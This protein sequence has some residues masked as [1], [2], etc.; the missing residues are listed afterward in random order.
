MQDDSQKKPI[1][2]EEQ[3]VLHLKDKGVTF[4]LYS[5]ND[6][7]KYL[8]NNNYYF[9]LA[10]YRKNFEQYQGGEKDGKYVNLDFGYLR[11]LAIIDM[12]LRYILLQMALDIEHYAKMDILRE[13]EKH[14]EDGYEICDDFIDSLDVKQK[15]RLSDEIERNKNTI[16]C[17][18]M[19][20]KYPEHFPVWVFLELIPF[21]RMLSFYGFCAKR[22]AEEKMKDQ[23]YMLLS[24][25][26]VRNAAAHSSCI[27]NDLH[28]KT[29]KH[30]T[31]YAV[32]NELSKIEEISD[33]MRQKR[34]SNAR[35]QE[36]VTLL[37]VHNKIVTSEGIHNKVVN[38]LS[39]F[40]ER[41]MKNINYYEK[42]DLISASFSFLKIVIDKWYQ[43]R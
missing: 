30:K 17:G 38:Q 13:I 31:K 12:K 39:D 23:Y 41:M 2:T 25:K 14:G 35:I 7:I 28:N 20:A 24:C 6:A 42:N 37:Y 10:S 1:L 26:E 16:Y 5:E 29:Q 9:K 19:F 11:D 27:I 18:D 33:D 22:F 15:Q 40:E 36:I 3:L 32:M 8:G 21:G 43:K 4:S 34:M